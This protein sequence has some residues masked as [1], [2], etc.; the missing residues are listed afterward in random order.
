MSPAYINLNLQPGEA[1]EGLKRV[2]GHLLTNPSFVTQIQQNAEST[3][4]PYNL[5]PA[6]KAVL[7]RVDAGALQRIQVSTTAQN[8]LCICIPFRP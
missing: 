4:G 7:S 5:K 3:L 2:I 1:S 8:T 6:E